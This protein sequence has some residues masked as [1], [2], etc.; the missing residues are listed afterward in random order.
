MPPPRP[1][2][3]LGHVIA[4]YYSSAYV[5]TYMASTIDAISE[6]GGGW[7]LHAQQVTYKSVDPPVIGD[8]KPQPSRFQH[9][10][11]TEE[12]LT[13]MVE[14]AR[15]RGMKFGLVMELIYTD[16]LD[17]TL[18]PYGEQNM[19]AGGRAE[20]TVGEWA[21]RLALG[22]PAAQAYWDAW[23]DQYT[24]AVVKNAEIAQ[25]L[26]IELFAVGKQAGAVTREENAPR[27]KKLIAQVR[28][29]YSGKLTYVSLS[30]EGAGEYA[31]FPWADLDYVTFYGGPRI[32]VSI[33]DQPSVADLK[34]AFEKNND[35]VFEPVS[36]AA[37]K[38][39]LFLTAFM[40]RTQA[41]EQ[42]W[43]EWGQPHPEIGLD[44]TI[45]AKLT[46]AFFQAME[47]ESWVAGLFSWGFWW[48]DDTDA[49][50]VPGDASYSK[51]S[52][53]RNK[54]ATGI[55]RKWAGQAP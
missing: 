31:S 6:A 27:W 9:R 26:G 8:P 2:F 50:L 14:A 13:L 32:S 17:P 24:A 28:Q 33:R 40:S 12:E 45:Q 7:T 52:S 10:T 34:A 54:P 29:E 3:I 25:R 37:G 36:K 22:D 1:G 46:E 48:R 44:L 15:A 20:E 4:D 23:F 19:N 18:D 41:V 38:P 55:W 49:T 51:G 5:D 30:G 42:E 21:D 11:A 39:A 47:D 35:E 53:V 16:L 43:F